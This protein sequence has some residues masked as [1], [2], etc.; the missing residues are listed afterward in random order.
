MFKTSFKLS[1]LLLIVSGFMLSGC[2]ESLSKLRNDF[3]DSFSSL[4]KR[5]TDKNTENEQSSGFV[6][7]K[8][9]PEVKIIDDLGVLREYTDNA[10]PSSDTL[11]SS[12]IMDVSHKSCLYNKDHNS[13]VLQLTIS[14]SG[15]LGKR[16]RIFKGDKP[17]FSYPYF[18]GVADKYDNIVAKEIFA[19]SVE[20]ASTQTTIVHEEIVRQIIYLEAPEDGT[21]YTVLLGFQLTEEQLEHNRAM[22][23][24]M[25]NG[26]WNDARDDIVQ[27]EA[28]SYDKK[29]SVSMVFPSPEIPLPRKPE[30]SKPKVKIEKKESAKISEEKVKELP[31]ANDNQDYERDIG[32][33]VIEVNDSDNTIVVDD[34]TSESPV[35]PDSADRPEKQIKQDLQ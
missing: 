20:Y 18:V 25:G 33:D 28:K 10:N 30:I 6:D 29:N 8:S 12:A 5:N 21:D 35:V 15:E 26:A 19:A 4:G 22:K 23:E 3:A 1:V 16:A 9:C 27:P 2:N 14:I 32:T 31:E 34:I 7:I 13:V 11:V 17:N 24:Q